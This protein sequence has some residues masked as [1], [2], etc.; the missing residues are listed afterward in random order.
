[1]SDADSSHL[2]ESFTHL[3]AT[4]RDTEGWADFYRRALPYVL[5]IGRAYLFQS[6]P[7]SDYEDLAQNVFWQLSRAVH[8]GTLRAPESESQLHALLRRMASNQA[9]DMLRAQHRALRDERRR[10]EP[11][12][13]SEAVL[14]VSDERPEASLELQELV[15]QMKEKLSAWECTVLARLIEGRSDED[16]IREFGC[17]PKKLQRAKHAIKE[18]AKRELRA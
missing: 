13:G 11:F 9:K 6:S 14:A 8:A 3:L 18:R 5:T 17:S 4:P 10:S 7:A 2:L 15:A 12:D 16:V 1:M